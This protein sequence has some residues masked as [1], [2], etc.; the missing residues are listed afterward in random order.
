MAFRSALSASQFRT[1]FGKLNIQSGKPVAEFLLF[2]SHPLEFGRFERFE[3]GTIN[4]ARGSLV[5]T[6]HASGREWPLDTRL[7]EG[8]EKAVGS[9]CGCARLPVF[10]ARECLVNQF[11]RER[12]VTHCLVTLRQALGFD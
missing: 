2:I 12:D 6:A 8:L 1:D 11:L 4:A 3:F 10:L 9:I 5:E 7:N